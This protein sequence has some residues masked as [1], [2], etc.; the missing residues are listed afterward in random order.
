MQRHP[1]LH[2]RRV[3]KLKRSCEAVMVAALTKRYLKTNT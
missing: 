2:V 3:M 1:A